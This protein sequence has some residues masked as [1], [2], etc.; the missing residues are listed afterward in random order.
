MWELILPGK[1]SVNRIRTAAPGKHSDGGGLFLLVRENGSKFFV[2][3]TT[4]H[5]RRRDIG[6]GPTWRVTLAEAREEALGL[7][8]IAREGGDPLAL[9]AKRET[10]HTFA[11]A[12]QIVWDMKKDGWRNAKHVKQWIAT[13]ETYAHPHI[14]AMKINTVTSA[15]VLDV[16]NPIWLSKP[17][18]A[19]R[20]RQRMEEVFRWAK[21]ANHVSGDNPVEAVKPVLPKS[22]ATP[23]HHTALEWNEAPNFYD[24]LR[25]REAISAQALRFVILTAAR[26]GEVRG[27]CWDEIDL[28]SKIWSIPASRMKAGRA[29]RVPLTDEALDILQTVSELHEELVFPSRHGRKMSDMTFKAL[30]KRMGRADLTAHG[31]RSTFR[32][33]CSEVALAPRELAEAALAHATGDATERAYA[34]SDLLDRRRDLMEEWAKFVCC[35]HFKG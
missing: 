28:K 15:H 22:R 29:H 27:A 18:T 4:V 11:E 20:V 9:R 34:R 25:A 16:L 8:R 2:L 14:G 17:E 1:L 3:R 5:G 6:L 23:R 30:L 33:W 19:R 24:E 31:F 10:T 35:R 26:S 12:A 13:L 21:A 7:R 32:D